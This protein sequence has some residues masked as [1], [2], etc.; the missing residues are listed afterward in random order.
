M[1]GWVDEQLEKNGWGG[2]GRIGGKIKC[3]HR[4]DEERKGRRGGE[5]GP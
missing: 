4:G 2:M 1:D 3:K 5:E